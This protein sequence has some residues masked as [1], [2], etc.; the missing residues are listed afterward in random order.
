MKVTSA[1]LFL[2]STIAGTAS[3]C[4]TVVQ[5]G[6]PIVAPSASNLQLSGAVGT[7]ATLTLSGLQKGW[8]FS[9]G[10]LGSPQYCTGQWLNIVNGSKPWKKLVWGS[11][12]QTTTWRTGYNADLTAKKTA[13]YNETSN[14]LACSP[15]YPTFAP[16]MS[17][18]LLTDDTVALP[19]VTDD[20]LGDINP[21]SCVKTKLHIQPL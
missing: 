15:S 7:Q 12:Q 3:A 6:P 8:N 1:I 17:V 21:A 2:A 20:V 4:V 14:F 11:T 18:F 9:N 13:S 5:E 19:T 10:G 16:Q